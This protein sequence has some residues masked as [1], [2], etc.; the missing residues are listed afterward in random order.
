MSNTKLTR[1]HEE[2]LN[3]IPLLEPPLFFAPLH[4]GEGLF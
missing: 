4:L 2:T 3:T 1:K